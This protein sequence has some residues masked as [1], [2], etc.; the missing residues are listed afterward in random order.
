MILTGRR[1]PN[2]TLG[3]CCRLTKS[4]LSGSVCKNALAMCEPES[5]PG[6]ISWPAISIT[7]LPRVW[8]ER[9][10]HRPRELSHVTLRRSK[11]DNVVWGQQ[12]L[13]EG[14]GVFKIV[15]KLSLAVL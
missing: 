12:G 8:P 7:F 15:L 1:G 4:F 11:T 9:E 14:R 3:V 2:P 5:F 6:D 10:S 13:E